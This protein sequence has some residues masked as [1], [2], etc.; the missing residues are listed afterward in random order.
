MHDLR[1]L[2]DRG[3]RYA[4]ALTGDLPAA[5]DLLQEA[6]ASVLS[7]GRVGSAPY[8]F[9]AIRSRWIDGHRRAAARPVLVSE[10]ERGAPPEVER[11]MV[12]DALWMGLLSLPPAQRE[13]LYLNLVE[14]WTAEE[15][16]HRVGSPRNTILSHLRRG[17][18]ALKLWLRT[19]LE[20]VG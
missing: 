7:A 5:E 15:I 2:Q 16:G 14:G 10:V 12:A 20:E 3:L 13:A 11:L 9:T 4:V 18:A 6:W 1:A 17:R 8:L 19:N